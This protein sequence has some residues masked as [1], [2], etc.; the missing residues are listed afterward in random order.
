MK[1][2]LKI[3]GLWG[4]VW[5]MLPCPIPAVEGKP[6]GDEKE[7]LRAW[8]VKEEEVTGLLWLALEDGQKRRMMLLSFG[9]LCRL[10][11]LTNV[12]GMQD[13]GALRPSDY[14]IK[15]LNTE[16]HSMA[17]ICALPAECNTPVFPLLLLSDLDLKKLQAA[18]Q[19]E[20]TQH[21]SHSIDSTT[22][23]DPRASNTPHI[24]QKPTTSMSDSHC[25][26]CDGFGHLQSVC[27][28]KE[29]VSKLVK[30]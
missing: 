9:R 13:L 22:S 1:V 2:L 17:L 15:E 24:T 18:F 27:F 26:F 8:K 3:K 10:Y 23:L 16:L 14:T 29:D 6:S 20:E 28:K 25:T 5:G 7:L 11:I 4:L 12:L 21:Q 30:G 19:S